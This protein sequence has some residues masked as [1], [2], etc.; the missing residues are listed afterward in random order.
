MKTR[1]DTLATDDMAL[2]VSTVAVWIE[3]VVLDETIEEN[4]CSKL[5]VSVSYPR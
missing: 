5:I 2:P 3:A 4:S 1:L